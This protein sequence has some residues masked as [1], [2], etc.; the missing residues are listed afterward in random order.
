MFYLDIIKHFISSTYWDG[1]R[2]VPYLLIG[3]LLVGMV[4]L[5]S[6]WY[7]LNSKTVYGIYIFV[8]GAVVTIVLNYIF[9]PKFGFMAC[10]VAN[11]VCY[12][13]MLI[14]TFLWGRKYLVCKYDFKNI[15][16]YLG[17][18]VGFY[19]ISLWAENVIVNTILLMVFVAVVAIRE[20]LKEQLLKF[21]KK[22]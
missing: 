9:V 22:I 14:I 5:Q 10:A 18:T 4:Y 17:L 7:K 1:L 15:V 19:A 16:L 12:L 8:I 2:V 13:I 21:R 11:V 6:F 20:N 3:H